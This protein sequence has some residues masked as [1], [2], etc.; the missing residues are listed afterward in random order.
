MKNNIAICEPQPISLALQRRFISPDPPSEQLLLRQ[1]HPVPAYILDLMTA[2]EFEE[3]CS[4]L[5]LA[6]VEYGNRYRRLGW[7]VVEERAQLLGQHIG[8]VP[9]MAY[10]LQ[11]KETSFGGP[12]CFLR[13]ISPVP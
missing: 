12:G 9:A 6:A 11:V 10:N 3:F 4:F 2:D 5:I 7:R 8:I 13:N 1:L